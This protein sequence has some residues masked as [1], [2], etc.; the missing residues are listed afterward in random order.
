MTSAAM[1]KSSLKS[2]RAPVAT[3]SGRSQCRARSPTGT[4]RKPG[5]WQHNDEHHDGRPIAPDWRHRGGA[6]LDRRP[7]H[8]QRQPPGP[9]HHEG[10]RRPALTL[11]TAQDNQ[12]E[13]VRQTE[14]EPALTP[15]TQ[16]SASSRRTRR[17]ATSPSATSSAMLVAAKLSRRSKEVCDERVGIPP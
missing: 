14:M 17:L 9:H 15:P 11:K 3:S 10:R 5:L 1:P 16:R 8:E 12:R 7:R 13:G 2:S 4:A 6:L